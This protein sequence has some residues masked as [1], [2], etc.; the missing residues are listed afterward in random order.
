MSNQG[1]FYFAENLI[2]GFG[3]TKFLQVFHRAD[4]SA[5]ADLVGSIVDRAGPIW[6][7][8]PVP[9][10]MTKPQAVLE[11]LRSHRGVLSIEPNDP[12]VQKTELAG[13]SRTISIKRTHMY[14]ADV[15]AL[16]GI[17]LEAQFLIDYERVTSCTFSLQA[18]ARVEYIP[19]GYL[20]SLHRWCDGNYR[21]AMPEVSIKVDREYIV[22]QVLIAR[23]VSMQF[24][25]KE[26]FDIST[27]AKI[28]QLNA[29][30]GAKVK[31]G[32]VNETTLGVSVIDNVDYLIGLKVIDWDDL[33]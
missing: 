6:S 4:T 11:S 12:I 17:P 7:R 19:T 3:K 21:V 23:N 2:T 1:Q 29:T 13:V 24:S 20:A 28:E 10:H 14:Q 25:S 18:G 8:Y 9:F 33:G 22:D 27:E 26:K 16:P 5:G 30:V 32:L 15:A 31:F